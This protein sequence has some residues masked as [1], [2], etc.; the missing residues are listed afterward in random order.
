MPVSD[1]VRLQVEQAERHARAQA[2]AAGSTPGEAARA[3][4]RARS[5]AIKGSAHRAGVSP[6]TV[7]RWAAGKQR[8]S[9]QVE[10]A[11]R[12]RV[13]RAA[14]GGRGLQA[15]QL[16]KQTQANVGH[17][18]VTITTGARPGTETRNIGLQ[19][20]DPQVM[21]DV[22]DLYRDGHDE[23]AADM[24]Q[25]HLLAQYGG[26][27]TSGVHLDDIMYITEFADGLPWQEG[28]FDLDD[29]QGE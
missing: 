15:A 28:T 9:R 23:Q 14:G 26:A 29:G 2:I 10:Q 20:L 27:N 12:R 6:A 5:E 1:M 18:K 24:F 11:S 16:E 19:H 21:T 7:R 17:V 22:A 4:S 25:R 8:S 13:Q 3:G